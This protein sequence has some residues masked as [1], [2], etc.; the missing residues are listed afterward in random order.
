MSETTPNPA[1]QKSKNPTII[2]LCVMLVAAIVLA[3]VGFAGKDSATRTNADL[4]TQLAELQVSYDECAQNLTN[5]EAALETA[6]TTISELTTDKE[7]LE[8]RVATLEGDKSDLEASVSTLEGEKADLETAVT[9]LEGDKTTLEGTITTL[10]SDKTT[11]EGD[12]STLETANQELTTQLS[13]LQSEYDLYKTDAEARITELEAPAATAS[14]L[15]G[16]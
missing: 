13:D 6:N 16:I 3:M 5:S 14:P 7:D 12:K 2:L 4:A 9:T 15:S 8:T 11:L 10:E 1:P